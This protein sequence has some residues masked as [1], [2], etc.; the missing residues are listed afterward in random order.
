MDKQNTQKSDQ[1]SNNL[2]APVMRRSVDEDSMYIVSEITQYLVA[3]LDLNF[4]NM[5]LLNNISHHGSRM[6]T[7]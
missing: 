2:S 6:A 3:Q 7:S 1:A 4:A 5:H